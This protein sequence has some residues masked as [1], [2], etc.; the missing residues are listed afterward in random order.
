M[1]NDR[2]TDILEE[3]KKIRELLEP[4]PAPK[5]KGNDGQNSR[6]PNECSRKDPQK[7]HP[8]NA[9]NGHLVQEWQPNSS[10][11]LF[12][13]LQEQLF[14][15]RVQRNIEQKI[16]EQKISTLSSSVHSYGS[17]GYYGSD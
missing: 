16:I 15:D 17:Q 12:L 2:Q 8:K 1:S 7:I 13:V 14:V 9:A 6:L 5:P 10:L 3:L 11:A 4:K